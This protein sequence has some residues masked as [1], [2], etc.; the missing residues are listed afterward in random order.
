MTLEEAVKVGLALVAILHQLYLVSRQKLPTNSAAIFVLL[1]VSVAPPLIY[2]REILLLYDPISGAHISIWTA[3]LTVCTIIGI[4]VFSPVNARGSR[5]FLLLGFGFILAA[6]PKAFM[7]GNKT[8]FF[9]Q[10]IIFA[11]PAFYG[12]S[13]SIVARRNLALFCKAFYGSFL[14][15]IGILA[16]QLAYSGPFS[17]IESTR[18]QSW[19]VTGAIFINGGLPEIGTALAY[20]LPPLLVILFSGLPSGRVLSLVA[21]SLPFVMNTR[22]AAALIISATFLGY[23]G[24]GGANLEARKS[25]GGRQRHGLGAAKRL[26]LISVLVILGAT[27]FVS[28]SFEGEVLDWTTVQYFEQTAGGFSEIKHNPVLG[29]DYMVHTKVSATKTTE[30][31]KSYV[32]VLVPGVSTY[33]KFGL[34]TFFVTLL[35]I[36]IPVAYIF[37]SRNLPRRS[38]NLYIFLVLLP[39]VPGLGLGQSWGAYDVREINVAMGEM[40]AFPLEPIFSISCVITLILILRLTNVS[41]QHYGKLLEAEWR[42]KSYF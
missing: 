25:D 27:V 6:L 3:C 9:D 26:L 42:R 10:V 19:H 2:A 17:G 34:L 29:A 32:N 23:S 16:L 41:W 11:L 8:Y 24:K 12:F 15:F 36:L 30:N 37:K 1:P 7:F 4:S 18:E 35:A 28:R 22:A 21:M 38:R 14:W 13:I 39:V 5:F 33:S 40:R 20:F 31:I